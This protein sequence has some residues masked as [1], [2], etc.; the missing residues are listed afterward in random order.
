MK[1]I[2]IFLFLIGLA[3]SAKAQSE[4]GTDSIAPVPPAEGGSILSEGVR[5][6]NGFLLDMDGLM[7]TAAPTL[8]RFTLEIPD[9]SKDYNF[10]M[11]PQTDAIYTQGLSNMFSGYG[12][13][14][15]G[16]WSLYSPG[17]TMD[18]LQMGSFRLKNGWRLNTY[19]EYNREGYKVYNP[20][21]LPWERNNFKGA[22]EFKSQDG[23][24][25]IRVEVQRGRK[26]PF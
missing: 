8:P 10:L 11:R 25:G 13:S 23:S 9:A 20:S 18:N 24:F 14:Y 2:V 4:I 21:A 3:L 26:T 6:Y 19:G 15:Y 5:S 12:M 17:G 1:P 16:P 22:F 7:K